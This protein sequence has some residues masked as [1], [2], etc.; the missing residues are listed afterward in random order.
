MKQTTK[1][2]N[3]LSCTDSLTWLKKRHMKTAKTHYLKSKQ[4]IKTDQE[5]SE[6]FTKIDYDKSGKIDVNEMRDMFL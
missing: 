1:K 3:L 5:I 6:V 2:N 4:E